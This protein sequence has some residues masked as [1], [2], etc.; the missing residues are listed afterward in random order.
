MHGSQ[1][2]GRAYRRVLLSAIGV[3]LLVALALPAPARS[4]ES[5]REI[6]R[7]A[8]DVYRFQNKFHYSVFLVTGEGVIATDPINAEAAAWLKAEIKRRFNQPV[9]YLVYSHEHPDHISGGEVFADTATVI[10]HE[11]AK[12][13]IIAKGIHTAVPDL[14]LTDRMTL[15]LGGKR[16]ELIYLGRNHSDNMIVMHFV[17]DGVLFGVDFASANRL[18]YRDLP[19][20]YLEE[21]IESLAKL[22]KIPFRILAPGHGPL[23]DPSHAASLARYLEEL[24][25]AVS[26]ELSAGRS[27]EQIKRTVT[28]DKYKGW[29]RYED[30]RELNVEG[31]VRILQNR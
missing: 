31:M 8:G 5:P 21:W 9:K 2:P 14:T 25:D 10:A 27:V 11:R 6:T 29:L 20:A 18:P 23:G 1:I 26:R 17:D 4:Q 3:G 16:V 7:I 15:E 28:M 30:W 22:Q 12:A 24:R 19:G 13:A